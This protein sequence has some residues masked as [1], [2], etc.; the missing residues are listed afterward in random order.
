MA[1]FDLFWQK[2]KQRLKGYGSGSGKPKAAKGASGSSS[3]IRRRRTRCKKCEPCTRSECGECTFCKD[4]RKFGGPGRMKQTCV[5]RQCMAV[6]RHGGLLSMLVCWQSLSSTQ[7]NSRADLLGDSGG[8]VNSHDFCPASLKS[9]G[10]FFFRCVL[11]S[12]WKAATVNLRIL[13]CQL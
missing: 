10:C 2:H 4:M 5:S 13:H 12:Q 3:T 6:S 8:F 7:G 1:L 11:S 9:L